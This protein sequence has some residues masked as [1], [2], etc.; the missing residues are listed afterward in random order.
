MAG[1]PLRW[2]QVWKPQSE[3]SGCD[4]TPQSASA[5]AVPSVF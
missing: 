3:A 4:G 1:S 2:H 5:Q